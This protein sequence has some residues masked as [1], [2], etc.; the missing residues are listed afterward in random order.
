[1]RLVPLTVGALRALADRDQ[2]TATAETGLAITS[3]LV[4]DACVW[5]WQLRAEQV[6]RDPE[7]LHWV[8]R[9]AQDVSTGAVV[10]H[11][12]FHGPP[13]ERGMVEVAYHTD[14]EHRRRGYARAML[15]AALEWASGSSQVEVVRASISPENLAS[16][17]TLAGFGFEPAG[18]QWDEED[19]LEL[20]YERP[21]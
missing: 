12:G 8:A 18:E 16:L 3:Y 11:A 5:L 4:S 6:R 9:P 7:A 20:L 13:D 21:V 17:A 15:T 1:M 2:E 10:G 19:G 14:P